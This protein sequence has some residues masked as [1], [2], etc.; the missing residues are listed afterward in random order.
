MAKLYGINT[1]MRGSVG[2][3]TYAQLHG[4]TIAKQKLIPKDVPTRT[5]K[6]MKRRVQLRNIQNLWSAFTNNLKPSFEDK[7]NLW[8]D[9]NAFTSANFGL[10]HV[11][12]NKSEARGGGC[13]FA[14]YQITRGSLPSINV[15]DST[16]GNI[17]KTDIAVGSTFSITSATTVKDFS[18]EIIA[19][20]AHYKNGDQI[21]VFILRQLVN[22]ATAVPYVVVEAEAFNL[23]TSDNVTKVRDVV[24]EDG[25]SI[26]D[27]CIGANN[28]INGGIAWVHSRETQNRTLVGTQ[29][30][31]V[32]NSL[33]AQYQTKAKM[34]EAIESYGG[35]DDVDFLTPKGN[36]DDEPGPGPVPPSDA[37]V[38]LNLDPEDAG[39]Y[40]INGEHVDVGAE[41]EYPVGSELEVH[42]E[43]ASGWTFGGWKNREETDPDIVVTVT[44]D[45]T[46]EAIVLED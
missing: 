28:T 37:T 21:A 25:F 17:K 44:G 27:E 5:P 2:D 40:T 34:N 19:H 12:L 43:A 13:V 22:A 33:L 24:S 38:I 42:F 35:T 18:D 36:D 39:A 29:F 11:Y 26:I 9:F 1:R 31:V 45:T 23:D 30:I 14:P 46:L 32:S 7:P 8:S 10:V 20:N 4:E 16:T 15:S 3:W 41:Y 6:Q